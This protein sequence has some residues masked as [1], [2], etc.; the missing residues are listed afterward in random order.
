M[1]N[2]VNACNADVIVPTPNVAD[3]CSVASVLNDYNNTANATD[4]Y[5]VGTTT[6]VWTVTDIYGNSS[7]CSMSVT[8]VDDEAPEVTCPAD[9][10]IGTDED[11]CETF[12]AI[13]APLVSDECGIASVLNDY[14]NTADASDIYPIGTTTI[15]WTVTDIHGN[16][17]TCSMTVTVV[18]D[19]NPTI[20]CPANITVNND[21]NSCDAMVT[22]PAIT[23]F[24]NCGI[25]TI[26]NDYTGTD[27][28]TAVYSVGTTTVN[29]TVT[30]VHGNVSTCS[31]TVTVVDPEL[32]TITCPADIMVN[33]DATVC[34]A[35]VTVDAPMV[36]DNC[37]I[38]SVV[39]D[40]TGTDNASA[41]YPVGTTLV[42]WTVTDIYGNTASCAM[43]IV[44]VDYELPNITCPADV[45][46]N[47]DGGVC[48][49]MVIVPTPSVDDNCGVASVVNDYTGTDNASAI[50]PVG[51]TIIT[52]TVTDIHGNVNTCTMSVN[53]ID[54]EAPSL[55]CP[56]DITVNN[57]INSC[58]AFITVPAPAV[59]DN[60]AV[61]TL[62]NDYTLTD[63]ATA[64]YPVGTTTV[65]W[66]L[67]D[68][69]GNVSTC[70]M[71]IT[72]VDLELP[73]ITCTADIIVVNDATECE[74][75]ITVPAPTVNDNCA[76]A[77]VLNDYNNT[78]DASDIYV[79]G[80]TIVTWT[81][82][83]I[84]GN[85]ASC[86]Q[87]I[88]VN[89]TELP[90]ITCPPN[91][92]SNT[93]AGVCEA[94]VAIAAPVVSDNCAVASV[95][96]DYTGTSDASAIYPQGTTMVTWTVTDIYGNAATCTQE[97]VV[98]DVEAPVVD[99]TDD[100]NVNT[101]AGVC[102]AMATVAAP[103]VSDNCGIASVVNDYTGVDNADGIYPQG[104]TTV[105]WTITDIHANVSTCSTTIT[106]NDVEQP[107]LNCPADITMNNDGGVCEAFINVPAPTVADNCAVATIVNDYNNTDNASD[108]YPVGTTTVI[109]TLTD[110]HGNV[111]TCTQTILIVD[112]ELPT[113]TCP[114][115]ITQTNDVGVC[116]AMVT[117]P[118]PT[119]AD[120]CTVASVANDYNGTDNASDVYPVGT[121]SVTWTVIDIYG[122]ASTC[123]MNITVTDDELPVV[124]CGADITV[125]NDTGV[126]EAF[127]SVPTPAFADNCTVANVMNDFTGTDNASAIYPVGT[128]TVTWT[129]SDINGNTST[130][131][132]TVT[133]NDD[134]SPSI[135][136]PVNINV[137]SD[138]D[139][140]DAM[141]TVPAP[142]MNDNC[143]V[144]TVVNDYNNTANATDTYPVGSTIVNWTVTDIYGNT[145]TCSMTIVVVDIEAPIILCPADISV[146]NTPGL[147][148]ALVPV[149]MPLVFDNCQ[150]DEVTND[151]NGTEDAS[152]IYL[153]GTTL[154]T[155][156]VTDIFGNSTTCEMN[157]VVIDTE[158]ATIE[159]PLNVI[160]GND[161]GECSAWVEVDS[162]IVSDNCGVAAVA[163]DYNGTGDASAD[164][165]VG[166]TPVIWTVIDANGNI[167][168]CVQL[169]TVEDTEA[170][171]ATD[172]DF[173]I[174]VPN[175]LDAC[176]AL[177]NYTIPVV[178]DN[179]GI[180][181]TTLIEG[182]PTGEFFP[183]GSTVV[184]YQF[185]DLFGNSVQCSFTV[186]VEDTQLPGVVCPG[187]LELNNDPG[188]C[189]AIVNYSLPAFV[190]NCDEVESTIEL[191]EGL[192]TGGFFEVGT[193]AVS[194][195]I[196]DG[197]GNVFTCNFTVTVYDTEAP[198]ID[199]PEDINQVDPI[200]IYADPEV[201]DNCESTLEI[202]EGLP[203]GDVF[204]HGY[205][206]IVY[207]ATDPAGQTDTCSFVVLVNTP[208]VAEDDEAVYTED[209]DEITI[210]VTDNDY[211]L[212]G[213]SITV[214]DAWS[215]N[216]NDVTIVDNQ[217]IYNT[218]DEWCGIDTVTYILCDTYSACDTAI[219]VINVECII[220]LIIPQGISPDGD[221]VND[222]FEIIGLEDYPDNKLAI[223][224][225]W[226]HKVFEASQY[227]NDWDGR[228]Q[229]AL[230]IGDALLPKGTYFF[231][232]DL[233]SSVKAVKGYIYLNR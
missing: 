119:V 54:N 126:C 22:V 121:T 97:I 76:I 209:D 94:F 41:I 220:D 35:F 124:T 43:N 52:W 216:G 198:Q 177:V 61:A 11:V 74:A 160:A 157:I 79:V 12:V 210:D 183:V 169:I 227:K 136:C 188:M 161:A 171:V 224:N 37:S 42:T 203:S 3:N 159:C 82:T 8:V 144:A 88:I 53:V 181:E 13:N 65:N 28:A 23:V 110:V 214:T 204:P 45:S 21:A 101:D 231:V 108:V 151:F 44:V 196:T 5:P 40:Y 72:V 50:Y 83:D 58:D 193:T 208:P 179:C 2:D 153:A 202:I 122:N 116:A 219:I 17:T 56:A 112:T 163:N 123:T 189:G 170:P 226:G 114:A 185:S 142:V 57:D 7:T 225:R 106:V 168:T 64:T 86:T 55:T 192:P 199:C 195:N 233:G 69:Y 118:A 207:V 158:P 215:Q 139:M 78:A 194:Y 25:A 222:V 167:T 10:T 95:V 228:S 154:V 14:N 68:I 20:T 16:V 102:E 150:I 205:T 63:N 174:T 18:D 15:A 140:C 223:F 103:V 117:V 155:W 32:P 162:P 172:C 200:V 19:E 213:D 129:V 134:E 211:D 229:D 131:S 218:I 62:V 36:N 81:V 180:N 176:G 85:T 24:D 39:N 201:T 46:V 184:T 48:Q 89:D 191:V 212:D 146:N 148:T 105:T 128:T 60:C 232:L 133:V 206:T 27:N 186:T 145:S 149:P 152:G 100:I 187:N 197:S 75:F 165:P 125:G 93:D 107:S 135:S 66:T 217:I 109:W 4:N 147:C 33:N 138:A 137:I 96:N 120:N 73:T 143:G 178:T 156:T 221:G 182:L 31:M 84:F 38:A 190:D 230:T 71:T 113:I 98:N 111:S 26:V 30:D 175:D 87:T 127:V 9:I 164:Y 34:E 141:L 104:S 51:T 166:V 99:C 92:A 29:W 77:S 47:N 59:A 80:T 6:I 67:T 49:A 90:T 173:E 132:M 91:L 70:S 115:D 1:S 130:C